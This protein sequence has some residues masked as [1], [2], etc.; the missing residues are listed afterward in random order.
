MA[1]RLAAYNHNRAAPES[2][3]NSQFPLRQIP[4]EMQPAAAS[5]GPRQPVYYADRL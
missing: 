2:A 1:M 3:P 5:R 4:P